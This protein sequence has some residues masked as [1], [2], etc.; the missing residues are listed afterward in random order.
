MLKPVPEQFVS[1]RIIVSKAYKRPQLCAS[2]LIFIFYG[3]KDR[4]CS[5]GV[6][7]E[8]IKSFEQP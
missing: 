5:R 8:L 1:Q 3:P 6:I 7:S 2:L 4:C